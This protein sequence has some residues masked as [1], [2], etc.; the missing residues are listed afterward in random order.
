[1]N[2]IIIFRQD[3][4]ETRWAGWT[5]YK[6]IL[7]QEWNK[8]SIHL[9]RKQSMFFNLIS[10]MN[11][12][13]VYSVVFSIDQSTFPG[14]VWWEGR[15]SGWWCFVSKETFIMVMCLLWQGTWEIPRKTGR[16]QGL[17]PIPTK[18][19]KSWTYGQGN[20]FDFFLF[21]LFSIFLEKELFFKKKTLNHTKIH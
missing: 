12:Y 2:N 9:Y 3:S 14:C 20:Y 19:Y 5:I 17:G 18:K 13:F 8:E 4:R 15:K 10:Q 1:M 7:R 11:F 16:L 6:E 21:F